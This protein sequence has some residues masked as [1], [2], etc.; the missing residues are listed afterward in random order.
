M[1]VI[2]HL[3]REH[4]EAGLAVVRDQIECVN[5]PTTLFEILPKPLEK[6]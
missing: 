6:A 2:P 3:M 1:D 5:I 4:V